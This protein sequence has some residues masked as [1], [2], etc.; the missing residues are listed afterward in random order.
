MVFVPSMIAI[1]VYIGMTNG[2]AYYS[3]TIV[4]KQYVP[5][6]Y[7]KEERITSFKPLETRMVDVFHDQYWITKI[8]SNQPGE[9]E[10]KVFMVSKW[11]YE[12]LEIGT[13]H[14][15]IRGRAHEVLSL[16]SSCVQ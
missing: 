8:S 1:M 10:S 14:T 9:A 4:S 6:R 16:D 11:E 13:Y 2:E 5:G 15:V 3:G 12:Q 7:C